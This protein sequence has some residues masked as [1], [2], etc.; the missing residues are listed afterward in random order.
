[1]SIEK[2]RE[3]SRSRT[4]YKRYYGTNQKKTNND[5]LSNLLGMLSLESNNTEHKKSSRKKKLQK[6]REHRVSQKQ[7]EKEE[8]ER[9]MKFENDFKELQIQNL[10]LKKLQMELQQ[11]QER[12]KQQLIVN[13]NSCQILTRGGIQC[14]MDYMKGGTCQSFCITN[15]WRLMKQVL[16]LLVH[17]LMVSSPS[18]GTINQEWA[19]LQ[20]EDENNSLVA[21]IKKL[22]DNMIEIQWSNGIHKLSLNN[23]GTWLVEQLWFRDLVISQSFSFYSVWDP[24][25]ESP[26]MTIR[27]T[28]LPGI[29]LQSLPFIFD[30]NELKLKIN[31]A[32]WHVPLV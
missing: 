28:T 20:I 21:R 26:N 29:D 4:R 14:L 3:R 23:L 5:P 2:T 32:R 24:I 10:D 13:E 8:Q 15:Y 17:P 9:R 18:N 7:K 30:D 1:M 31:C 6:L 11:D 16:N 19:L 25:Y 27:S 22:D 12:K